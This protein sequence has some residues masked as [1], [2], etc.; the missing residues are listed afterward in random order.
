[1][2]EGPEITGTARYLNTLIK[3]KNLEKIKIIS[4]PYKN[5]KHERYVKLRNSVKELNEFLKKPQNSVKIMEVDNHG[6]YMWI[7]IKKLENNKSAGIC[8]I[9]NTYGLTGHWS[10]K[11]GEYVRLTFEFAKKITLHY[12]DK[13]QFGNFYVWNL[14]Q[15]NEK[16][17]ALGYDLYDMKKSEFLECMKLVKLKNPRKLL[18][19]VLMDSSIIAGIGNY[20]RAE[21]I[22]DFQKTCKINPFIRVSE[23]TNTQLKTL[24]T[25]IKNNAEKFLK[26]YSQD[27]IKANTGFQVYMKKKTAKNEIVKKK[28]D[29]DG[30][31]FWYVE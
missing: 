22:Y 20:L 13:L 5:H 23:I 18:L 1:M 14:K 17:Q 7:K 8:Y 3:N 9:G 15:H 31:T 29:A 10:I 26:S 21:I 30:R 19:R 16:L 24:Y 2:P 12:H 11:P 28:R 25:V 6:K 4:G 27:S